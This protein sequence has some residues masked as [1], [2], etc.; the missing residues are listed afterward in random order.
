MPRP[1]AALRLLLAAGFGVSLTATAPLRAQPRTPARDVAVRILPFERDS[2]ASASY[3]EAIALY[4]VLAAA[5]PDA[6]RLVEVGRTD[7]QLPLHL[8]LLGRDLPADPF[9]A[10]DGVVSTRFGSSVRARPTLFVNNA[11]H[12]GESCG[13]DASLLFARDLLA[14][15]LD[16]LPP[17]GLVAIVPAYN[18]GGM[19]RRG[20]DTRANQV[21]PRAHGFRGNARNLDLNRDFAKQDSRNARALTRLLRAL[22]PDVFVDTHTTNGS[23][24][25]Y[26][27][28]VL[29]TQPDKLGPVLGPLLRDTVLPRLEAGMAARGYLTFPYFYTDGPPQEAAALMPFVE[30]PRYSSGY[31]ALLH[32][33]GFISEAHA[34]K[35][36]ARRVRATEAFLWETYRFWAEHHAL[37]ARRRAQNRAAIFAQDSITLAWA[38]DTTRADTLPFRGYAPVREPSAVTGAERLRYDRA[39][40]VTAEVLRYSYLRPAVRV[41]R[42]RGYFVPALYDDLVER[43]G[44]ASSYYLPAAGEERQRVGRYA[45]EGF[46]T[47]TRPYEGHYLHYDVE[48][49]LAVSED[50]L[51]GL[52]TYLELTPA[53]ARLLTALFEPQAPDSYFAWGSFDSYLQRKEH[54]SAYLFEDTAARMLAE[55]ADLR[56]AFERRRDA[57]DAFRQNPRAQLDWLYERSE[58]YEGPMRY[59]VLR[60]ERGE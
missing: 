23:D 32:T 11:I 5:Y 22:S 50:T 8:F 56:A 39:R 52:G 2:L 16:G 55:D 49:D 24:H 37:I 54:Y 47:A 43:T 10:D 38:V 27:L 36:F 6:C 18:V 25:Q 41:A 4:R 31:A 40:P 20:R 17:R 7:A 60:I 15:D 26:D 21:G 46:A 33:V 14:R 1:A 30:T 34:L 59:P 57:D 9:E 35:P 53:N 44:G 58:H 12:A 28:T 19:L 51:R 29:A 3:P 13:V 48:V 45:V 42:P